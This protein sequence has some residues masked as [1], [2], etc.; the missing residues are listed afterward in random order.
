MSTDPTQNPKPV[1]KADWKKNRDHSV[2][3]P[4]GSRITIRIPDIA[5]LVQSGQLPQ[6]LIDVALGRARTDSEEIPTNELVKQEIDFTNFVVKASVVAPVINDEDLPD[7]PFEDKD[8]IV[9]LA[10]RRRDL[11]A[12]GEHIAGL[13]KSEKFRRFRKLGEFSEDVE[14]L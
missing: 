14:G 10:T 12:E 7:I 4:S 13:S 3:A 1:S 6:N 5:L 8:F 11:D 2:M 9:Q